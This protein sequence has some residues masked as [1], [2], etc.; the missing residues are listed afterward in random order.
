MAESIRT[1]D[2]QNVAFTFVYCD[3]RD[4]PPLVADLIG[5]LL[6]QLVISSDSMPPDI[7]EEYDKEPEG[8]ANVCD[9]FASSCLYFDRILIFI[10]ALDE[11]DHFRELLIF[12][13]TL[14]CSVSIFTT[15]RKHVE[16]DIKYHLSNPLTIRIEASPTDIERLV[17]QRIQ[18][19]CEQRPNIKAMDDAL[20]RDII[21]K[22]RDLSQGL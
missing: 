17:K 13:H 10:D 18:T 20:E 8:Q 22:I 19:D 21:V 7:S 14:P 15:S 11:Y 9:L 12:L 4:Q 1:Q 16:A 6:R 2:A 5:G 3:Y